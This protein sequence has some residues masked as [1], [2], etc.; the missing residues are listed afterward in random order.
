LNG[1]SPKSRARSILYAGDQIIENVTTGYFYFQDSLG[2]TSHVTDSVGNLL[3]R[4]TYS[5]FGTPTFLSSNNTQL[6]TSA[7]GIRHL[8]QG[9]LWTQE[10][11]LNDYR[12]RVE[13]PAMGVFLQPDPIG[14]KGDAANIYRFCNN[15]AVNRIDP[16]GL[17]WSSEGFETVRDFSKIP[18]VYIVR[19]WQPYATGVT[20][21]RFWIDAEPVKLAN[22]K[23]AIEYHDAEMRS[24]SY[25]RNHF[26][27][28]YTGEQWDRCAEQVQRTRN[29]EGEQQNIDK[30]VYDRNEEAIKK[31]VK[32]GTYSS[33][34]DT[35]KAID[36]KEAKWKRILSAE[37]AAEGQK[38]QARD[39]YAPE[40]PNC[41]P[42]GSSPSAKDVD[43]NHQPTGVP[44]LGAEAV[45]QVN[46]KL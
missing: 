6:S 28:P 22:G 31:D 15:N 30:R 4:Y 21:Q 41:N 16:S 37:R 11:G 46:G 24:H 35:K 29:H 19:A 43:L 42:S 2:N 25:I 12:N 20:L 9:Q 8:F 40:S 13:L 32:S 45:N 7:Y 23:Y 26:V 5:A 34:N 27:K 1:A 38:L 44:S 39:G 18:N 10:T 17:I 36:K 33:Y 14:F 3:E